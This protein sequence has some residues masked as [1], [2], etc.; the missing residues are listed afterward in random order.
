RGWLEFCDN[1]PT[2]DCAVSVGCAC[3]GEF[4]DNHP[5]RRWRRRRWWRKRRRHVSA[6]SAGT[7]PDASCAGDSEYDMNAEEEEMNRPGANRT[8][9]DLTLKSSPD[10]FTAIT[11]WVCH[12]P[13]VIYRFQALVCSAVRQLIETKIAANCSA[14]TWNPFLLAVTNQISLNTEA[15]RCLF[16]TLDLL[17]SYA[18]S[19]VCYRVS[20]GRLGLS[21]QQRP[22]QSAISL[23]IS[24]SLTPADRLTRITVIANAES[25]TRVLLSLLRSL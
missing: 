3:S 25:P 14:V 20:R 24:D 22:A 12:H 16:G 4:S 6:G 23:V 9:E 10:A 7:G 2:W 21:A 18:C 15:S 19:I 17:R 8:E 11:H 1:K 13:G 5:T